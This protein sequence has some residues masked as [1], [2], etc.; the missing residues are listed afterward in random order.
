VI[1][2]CKSNSTDDLPENYVHPEAGYPR[3]KQLA[4]LE[5]GK[6]FVVYAIG[7][8]GE[9]VWYYVCESEEDP[10]PVGRP[11]PLFE[12][13]NPKASAYWQVDFRTDNPDCQMLVAPAEWFSEPDFY[14]RLTD[15]SE[16]EMKIF[17]DLRARMDSEAR[18]STS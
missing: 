8:F 16:R 7:L 3:G 9:K 5:V 15:W 4:N 13:V 12:T 10:Y 14:E 18:S 6:E 17:A 1:V 2:R 11:A